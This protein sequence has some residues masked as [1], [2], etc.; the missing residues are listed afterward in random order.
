MGT[1][2]VGRLNEL[3]VLGG[4]LASTGSDRARTVL[5]EAAGGMGKSALLSAFTEGLHGVRLASAR[6]D[7]DETGLDFG[8]CSQLLCAPASVWRDPFSA[9]ADVL[10]L[11]GDQ[12]GGGSVVLVVDDAHLADPISLRAITFALRRLHGDR[13]MTLLAARADHVDRLPSG[14]LRI[15][16]EQGGRLRLHGLSVAEI[17]DLGATLGRGHLSRRVAS[18]LR[19]HSG[20]SPLHLRALLTELTDDQLTRS[21]GPLPAPLSFASQVL[22][23]V[24]RTSPVSQRIACAAAVLG[25]RM[26]LDDIAAVADVPEAGFALEE[27]KRARIVRLRADSDGWHVQFE[28]PLVRAALY[29][30]VGPGTRAEF[31]S[32]A[33][34]L[35]GGPGALSHLVAATSR[36]DLPLAARVENEALTRRHTGNL[37]S[38]ADLM[39]SAVRLSGPGSDQDRRL[40]AAVE[41]VLL[42]GDAAAALAYSDRLDGIPPSAHRLSVQARMAWLSGDLDEAEQLAEQAWADGDR[43]DPS[44][45]D[46]LA[47]MLAQLFIM[48]DQGAIAAAWAREALSSG[49]LPPDQAGA[50][51]AAAAVGL[52]ISGRADEASL[53]LAELEPDPEQV[54][55]QRHRELRARGILR[56]ITDDLKGAR[57]DLAV[58]SSIARRELSASRLTAIGALAETDYRLGN[59][60]DSLALAEQA[61]SLLHDTEQFWLQGQIHT[62]A[63]LVLAGRGQWEE[64]ESHLVIAKQMAALLGDPAT[65]AYA[66]NAAIHLAMCRQDSPGVV[67]NS[68]R[69]ARGI[70][71]ASQEP[72]ILAWPVHYAAALVDVGRLDD[73]KRELGVFQEIALERGRRSRLAGLARVRA[74]LAIAQRELRAARAAFDEA[75]E[76]GDNSAE[77]L[78]QAMTHAAYG[79][80]LRRRGERRSAGRQLQLARVSFLELGASPFLQQCDSELTACGLAPAPPPKDHG[81]ALTPQERAVARLVCAGC[82]NQE[83]ADELVLSVKTVGYHL[84]NVY[85]KLEVHSRTQLINHP[86]MTRR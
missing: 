26:S 4:T 28:H 81:K 74:G 38:A 55:P 8:V 27:L 45:R 12:P 59:W 6:G 54:D 1:P 44:A 66:D 83:V 70:K 64:A 41:L 61:L 63:V 11:L 22:A 79:R 25:D 19:E 14:L 24:A 69:L 33:A 58:C 13:V 18:R 75:V 9:G 34:K 86:D 3:Q 2:F 39:F 85:L 56:L 37:R 29:D 20:G 72:G 23:S 10:R 35:L 31:H 47:A 48:K 15:V 42:T 73:A 16:D 53:L 40:L 68:D 5:V 52:T 21:D 51:R 36:P 76:L 67:A 65:A 77:A 57:A 17:V 32:R 78:E 80:F 50:T 46:S 43:L 49:R 84:G 62:V 71:G 30:D 7:E 82:T 60:D